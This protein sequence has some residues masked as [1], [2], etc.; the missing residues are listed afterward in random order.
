MFLLGDNIFSLGKLI[1][2]VNITNNHWFVICADFDKEEIQAYD[3]CPANDGRLPYLEIVFQYLQYEYLRCHEVQLPFPA[4]W[5]LIPCPPQNQIVP[6]QF[7]HNNNC[8]VYTCV[9][10]EFLLNNI[11]PWNLAD[12]D[13]QFALEYT[14]RLSL[15]Y[16]IQNNRTIFQNHYIVRHAVDSTHNDKPTSSTPLFPNFVGND[17]AIEAGKSEAEMQVNDAAIEAGKSEAEMQVT[18]TGELAEMFQYLQ[19]DITKSP[20]IEELTYHYL[21]HKFT[22]TDNDL[23]NL[24]PLKDPWD[25]VLRAP[26]LNDGV[27]WSYDPEQRI[28]MVDFSKVTVINEKHKLYLREVMERDDITVISEG[29]VR[30]VDDL[31]HVLDCFEREN[32]DT[33]FGYIRQFNRIVTGEDET[34]EEVSDGHLTMAVSDYVEYIRILTGDHPDQSFSY[35]DQDGRSI[36]VEKTSDVV[37]YMLDIFMPRLFTTFNNEFEQNFKMKELLPG[38]EW[39]ML[40]PVSQ[41]MNPVASLP[42]NP[43]V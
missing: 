38:G 29:F 43:V 4:N 41:A 28:V 37:F 5:K 9:L 18:S 22:Y 23:A 6:L 26:K 30:P 31:L 34:Y 7:E 42:M 27:E 13:V 32:K 24:E 16:S 8:C 1:I 12:S 10:M 40:N 36:T 14:G 19:V 15:W 11:D 25:F 39:C 21:G 2:P 20:Y 17:A 33:P 35:K 3:S